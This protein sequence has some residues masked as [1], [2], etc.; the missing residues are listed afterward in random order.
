MT[1]PRLLFVSPRFLF[2]LDEG[3]KI[4]TVGVLRAML[5]GAFDITLVSPAPPNV[6]DFKAELRSV[7]DRFVSWTP[8]KP[9]LLDKG[10]GV[11]GSLPVSTVSDQS[12]AGRAVVQD[13]IAI[14]ADVIVADFPHSNVLLP[15]KLAISSV[16][17]THNVEAEILERHAAV[18]KGW[19]RLVWQREAQKMARFERAVLRK[20]SSVVAVSQKDAVALSERYGLSNVHRI[21]TGVDLDFYPFQEQRARADVVVFSGAMD[22]RSNID[23]IVF[24]LR[25]V[26]PIVAAARPAVRVRIVGRNPPAA[27][28]AEAGVA[29]RTWRFTGFVEDIRPNLQAGDISVIPLRVGSGTRLKAFEAMA[30][31]LPVV[32]TTLGVEGLGL[33]PGT[34]YLAADRADTFAQAIIRLVDDLAERKRLAETGR[35]LLE[36][37]YSWAVIG[38]QFEEI[39]RQA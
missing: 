39:C 38:R 32:S 1:R 10:L 13:Q 15:N 35:A 14:R 7:A 6:A 9:G 36:A 34:H 31:G 17:F 16:M 37:R 18:T 23:G 25:E 19:R 3:G 2:P 21:D 20:F 4:R 22:S 11:L 30:I 29:F 8:T 26:W 5:G 24:L 12:I 27:L 28:V 33:E